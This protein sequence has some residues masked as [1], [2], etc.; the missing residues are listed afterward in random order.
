MNEPQVK[1]TIHIYTFSTS[2]SLTVYRYYYNIIFYYNIVTCVGIGKI[3]HWHAMWF[4]YGVIF[5]LKH[6]VCFSLLLFIVTVIMVARIWKLKYVL[7][8]KKIS[9]HWRNS[10]IIYLRTNNYYSI[11]CIRVTSKDYVIYRC[12]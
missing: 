1:C 3:T 10:T 8:L 11:H 4:T 6:C 12:D 7:D 2:Y 5:W 9:V